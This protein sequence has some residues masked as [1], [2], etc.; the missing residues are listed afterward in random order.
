MPG[1]P[2]TGVMLIKWVLNV[3]GKTPRTAPRTVPKVYMYCTVGHVLILLATLKRDVSSL[4][5]LQNCTVE[6]VQSRSP[7]QANKQTT[8]TTM[9]CTTDYV[10]AAH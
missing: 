4:L 6:G 2:F 7:K 10:M 5:H 3:T 9:S 1:L 8:T